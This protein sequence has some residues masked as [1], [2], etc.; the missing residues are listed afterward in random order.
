MA[1]NALVDAHILVEPKISV[2]EGHYIAESA[3]FAVLKNHHV[4]DVMIHIDPEDDMQKK[5]NA[6]LPSRANV[7]DHLERL[8]DESN[9]PVHRVVLHYLDGKIEAEIFIPAGKEAD[10][11]Q[12]KCDEVARKDP[13]IRAIRVY[14][15]DAL[16]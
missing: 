2:S 10:R 5:P 6:H 16:N 11:V 13:M 12:A 1:D 4:Q 9:L 7:L 3:R 15:S 14:R 8:L